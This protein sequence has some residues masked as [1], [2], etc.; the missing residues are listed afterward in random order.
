MVGPPT[1][2][3]RAGPRRLHEPY[4]RRN[5]E[6]A[7]LVERGRTPEAAGALLVYLDDA[8]RQLL[9]AVAE[10]DAPRRR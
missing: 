10:R 6:I 3:P 4:V 8:E 2:Q 7:T 5:R 1:L 9:A